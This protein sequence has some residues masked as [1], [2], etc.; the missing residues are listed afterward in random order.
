[1]TKVTKPSERVE[2]AAGRTS[3]TYLGGEFAL[4]PLETPEL[5]R[6][7]SFRNRE[8]EP[9]ANLPTRK[10]LGFVQGLAIKSP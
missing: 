7:G 2:L 3:R 1:M 4:Q 6:R 8:N 9:L 5:P 10:S